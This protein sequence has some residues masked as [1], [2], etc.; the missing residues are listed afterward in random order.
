LSGYSKRKDTNH[1]EITA[2]LVAAGVVV[3]DLS[4]MGGGWPDILTRYGDRWL[5]IEI[6]YENGELTDKEVQWWESVGV[7]PILARNPAEALALFGISTEPQTLD[8]PTHS[9]R[10]KS[11]RSGTPAS[12]TRSRKDDAKPIS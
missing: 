9:A 3:A 8:A 6:K 10:G 12:A 2:A 4:R 5:P 7:A 11:A 1:N